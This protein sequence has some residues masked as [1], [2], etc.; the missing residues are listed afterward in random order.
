MPEAGPPGVVG[1]GGG[2][3]SHILRSG[4]N[5]VNQRQGQHSNFTNRNRLGRTVLS[6][7]SRSLVSSSRVRSTSC[8]NTVICSS[9]SRTLT[10]L[11]SLNLL[12]QDGWAASACSRSSSFASFVSSCSRLRSCN[13]LSR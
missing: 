7:W 10:C 4:R 3:R 5:Q 9:I 2:S 6:R 8:R 12:E 1:V 11:S 13:S